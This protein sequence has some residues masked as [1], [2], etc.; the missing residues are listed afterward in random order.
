LGKKKKKKKKKKTDFWSVLE[1]TRK[2]KEK[3]HRLSNHKFASS[4]A[5]SQ[6]NCRPRWNP[7][8]Q[9]KTLNK[10]KNKNPIPLTQQHG[11]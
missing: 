6:K 2:K 10:G 5:D 3:I 9:K 8:P 11:S 4:S 1:A 7:N